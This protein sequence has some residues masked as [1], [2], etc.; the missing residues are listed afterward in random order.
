MNAEDSSFL[1][2]VV[3]QCA[4]GEWDQ[5]KTIVARTDRNDPNFP[6]AQVAEAFWFL[7]RR[8]PRDAI[9]LLELA[10]S[11]SRNQTL[12]AYG[13]I[14][15]AIFP[16]LEE[17]DSPYAWELLD[18]EAEYVLNQT[19]EQ[20]QSNPHEI[21][22]YFRRAEVVCHVDVEQDTPEQSETALNWID[23]GLCDA[24][25]AS[26]DATLAEKSLR[27]RSAIWKDRFST[28][29]DLRDCSDAADDLRRSMQA[30]EPD[31]EMGDYA[32]LLC[33]AHRYQ[34][35]LKVATPDSCR[36]RKRYFSIRGRCHHGLGNFAEA[37]ADFSEA[38]KEIRNRPSPSALSLEV[39]HFERAQCYYDLGEYALAIQDARTSQEFMENSNAA[40]SQARLVF[41]AQLRLGEMDKVAE[42][43]A[44]DV[45][46]N[47]NPIVALEE[48]GKY[49]LEKGQFL[50]AERDFLEL[51][52]RCPSDVAHAECLA[53][54]YR[55]QGKT[56]LAEKYSK[57]VTECIESLPYWLR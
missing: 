7:T 9:R 18:G 32:H 38:L 55:Q 39:A 29:N 25:I 52:R 23:A 24:T 36:S 6:A 44:K 17:Y 10:A 56:E 11:A 57:I 37:I 30:D 34:D 14:S 33:T 20:I 42:E 53:E 27:L 26:L 51:E 15:T 22:N 48:R 47:L 46:S 21:G 41:Q 54:L 40:S 35:A 50:E 4:S 2:A 49:F 1:D 8:E 5:V 28:T 45:E 16:R 31:E 43:I 3:A 12:Q 13:R 19:I